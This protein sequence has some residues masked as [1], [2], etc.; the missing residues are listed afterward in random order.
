[1]MKRRTG[2]KMGNNTESYRKLAE[3]YGVA[4]S[5]PF[6]KVLK[7]LITPEEGE[8]LLELPNPLTLAEL[9]GKVSIEPTRLQKMLDDMAR[10]GVVRLV[11]NGYTL[12]PHIMLMCHGT[13]NKND[14]VDRLWTDFFF[15][16][17]RYIIAEQSHKRRLTGM[18]S[19]HRIVPALQALAASPHIP[20]EQILWYENYEVMFRRSKMILFIPCSCR[21]QHRQCS[22]KMD[23]CVHVILDDDKNEHLLDGIL[24]RWPHLKPLTYREA[25]DEMYAAEDAGLGHLSLNYR[26]LEEAC[27]WCECCCRVV[28]PL[29]HA[30][31]DYD[32]MDPTKSRFQAGI[33]PDLCNGCQTCL[34]RCIFG[35]VE[36]VKVAGSKKM[37]ARVIE[38]KCMGCGLCVYTCPQKAIKFDIVRPPEHIPD[39]TQEQVF[40]WGPPASPQ[41]L[42]KAYRPRTG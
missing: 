27:N 36:M 40:S 15:K 38:K 16:E 12:P 25:M 7:A 29:I 2:E 35:A 41:E 22:N 26:R 24:Q 19:T 10:R 11:N 4:G 28:N 18:W 20:P 6:I 9:A 1:M 5:E 14:E 37:K 13:Q 23:L 34:E 8:I 42:Q 31:L 33:N 21:T 17:W 30:G 3:R 32:L 39:I